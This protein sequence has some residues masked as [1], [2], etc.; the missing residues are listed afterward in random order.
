[1]KLND[2]V[3][4]QKIDKKHTLKDKTYT[5]ITSLWAK[6]E[7]VEGK[8]ISELESVSSK[9][10]IK[11][12]IRYNK[13]LDSTNDANITQRYRIKYKN[14]YFNIK[15]SVPIKNKKYLKIVLEGE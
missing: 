13:L 3:Y 8:E 4:I 9:L 14:N 10:Y 5:D 7:N 2:R 1:M 6:I 15:S 12:I 11:I